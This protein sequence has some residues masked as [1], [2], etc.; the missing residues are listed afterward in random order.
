[1]YSN[2]S[3][4][5]ASE[6]EKWTTYSPVSKTSH[7]MR[8]NTYKY[9]QSHSQVCPLLTAP[10]YP[11]CDHLTSY[12]IIQVTRNREPLLTA[13]EQSIEGTGAILSQPCATPLIHTMTFCTVISLLQICKVLR[14]PSLCNKER[15]SPAVMDCMIWWLWWLHMVWSFV[16]YNVRIHKFMTFS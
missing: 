1:M 4:F 12:N 13:R 11:V 5:N 2:Q 15:S 8:S 9:R 3:L 16:H 10:V 14:L 7:Q 6:N